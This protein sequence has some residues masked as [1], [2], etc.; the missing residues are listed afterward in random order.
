MCSHLSVSAAA[1]VSGKDGHDA[2]NQLEEITE[3][4]MIC[5][6]QATCLYW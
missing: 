2:E 6:I 4:W 1:L 5:I 3:E